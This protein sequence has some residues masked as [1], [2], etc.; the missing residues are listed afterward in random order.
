MNV[1]E[2]LEGL[3]EKWRSTSRLAAEEL[4]G[5]ARDKVNQMGGVS[6]W[7]AR[8]EANVDRRRMW[9]EEAREEERKKLDA[10]L[11][12]DSDEDE[13]EGGEDEEDAQ[14]YADGVLRYKESLG[15]AEKQMLKAQAS[16]SRR[17]AREAR[18]EAKS[19]Y[20][21]IT[22]VEAEKREEKDSMWTVSGANGDDVSY[23]VRAIVDWAIADRSRT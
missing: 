2:E 3:I 12:S 1:D 14:R 7:R 13:H 6:G 17:R 8:D 19:E 9:E 4:Y 18:E 16:E 21:E 5:T 10:A 11:E 22:K 20:D 15:K 23:C